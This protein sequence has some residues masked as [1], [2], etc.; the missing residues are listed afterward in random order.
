MKFLKKLRTTAEV[1][2]TNFQD[3]TINKGDFDTY[4][5]RTVFHLPER[6][7]RNQ[8]LEVLRI[9]VPRQILVP[10]CFFWKI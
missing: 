5:G 1:T 6:L 9:L 7:L 2:L 10:L 4:C 3:P 8:Y